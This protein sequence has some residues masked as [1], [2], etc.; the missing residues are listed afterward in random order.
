MTTCPPKGPQ[1]A[2]PRK[3]TLGE[4]ACLVA[5]DGV[6]DEVGSGVGKSTGENGVCVE[7]V[8]DGSE[9]LGVW[10]SP[11][12]A[13]EVGNGYGSRLFKVGGDTPTTIVRA[14]RHSHLLRISLSPQ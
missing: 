3:D 13:I 1:L 11:L 10:R 8:Y 4:A 7:T 5:G 9:G 12:C 6:G 2:V 14:S